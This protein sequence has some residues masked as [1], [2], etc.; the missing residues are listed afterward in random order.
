MNLDVK[1]LVTILDSVLNEKVK[2][3]FLLENASSV[4]QN[5]EKF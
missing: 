3:L 1:L 4:S 5:I 2:I